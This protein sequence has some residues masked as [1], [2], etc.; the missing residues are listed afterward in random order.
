MTDITGANS[1]FTITVADLFSSPFQLQGYAADDA[2]ATDA[3][4]IAETLMGVDGIL[5]GG[6]VNVE[7]HQTISLQADSPSIT[8]F[9]QWFSAQKSNQE[10][11]TASAT[12]TMPA[13]GL[14][15]TLKNGFLTTYAP[16]AGVKK[17]LQPRQFAI[18]WNSVN[19]ANV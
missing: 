18:T 2:F 10:V 17:L 16:M 11:Y 5:S 13:V 12:I 6:F 8:Y 4:T 1:L 7:T 15:Y 9:D 14:K 19:W 3:M